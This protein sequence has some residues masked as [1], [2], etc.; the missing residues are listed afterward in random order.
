MNINLKDKVIAGIRMKNSTQSAFFVLA[1]IAFFSA[2]AA[3]Y[4]FTTPIGSVL[5]AG[6]TLGSPGSTKSLSSS[7]P[8]A[9]KEGSDGLYSIV[10]SPLD[11]PYTG[12]GVV[13]VS[14]SPFASTNGG[15]LTF[16]TFQA[17]SGGSTFDNIMQVSGSQEPDLLVNYGPLGE[18]E[19]LWLTGF[20]VYDQQTAPSVQSFALLD[21]G[22]AYQVTFNLPIHEPYSSNTVNQQTFQMLGQSWQI[23][24]YTLPSGTSSSSTTAV[25]GGKITV[26]SP[27]GSRWNLTN[28]QAL[29]QTLAPGWDVQLLWVNASGSGHYTDLQSIIIY[30][31]TPTMLLPGQS[32]SFVPPFSAWKLTFTGHTLGSNYDALTVSSTFAPA[33]AYKN[34]GTTSAGTGTGSIT[35]ITEPA[36]ELVLTS[37]IPNAFSYAGVSS[38]TATYVLTPYELNEYAHSSSSGNPVNVVLN[39]CMPQSPCSSAV[40]SADQLSVVLTGYTSSNSASP[41]STTLYF[42]SNSGVP[43]TSATSF[44]NIT[45]IKVSRALL[46]VTVTVTNSSG[47][48]LATLV[49]LS[50]AITYPQVGV[51]YSGLSTTTALTYNQQNGGPSATFGFTSTVSAATPG[52]PFT[53]DAY[54]ITEYNVPGSSSSTDS[55]IFNIDN[56]TAGWLASPLFQINFSQ[57]NVPNNLTYVSSQGHSVNARVGFVSE[58]GS[59]LAAISPTQIVLDLAKS[60][61]TLQFVVSQQSTVIT[62][63]TVT[64]TTITVQP[65]PS[66]TSTF[67]TTSTS[68]STTTTTISPVAGSYELILT[69][70]SLCASPISASSGYYAAASTVTISVSDCNGAEFTGWIGTGSGSYTG[71]VRTANVVMLGNIAEVA[72]YLTTTASTTSTSSTTSILPSNAYYLQMSATGRPSCAP[73]TAC[74]AYVLLLPN[75]CVSPSSGSYASGNTITIAANSTCNGAT[76]VDWSGTGA[77]S[78][79]GASASASVTMNGDITEDADYAIA[80]TGPTST[81]PT[82]SAVTTLPTTTISSYSTYTV[83]IQSGWNVFSVPLAYVTQLSGTCTSSNLMSPVWQLV[84][85]RYVQATFLYGGTGYWL[86]SDSDCSLTFSGPPLATAEAFTLTPGWN[87]VGS[88]GS[89][90]QFSDIS[91]GCNIVAGPYWYN[92]ASA[93]YQTESAMTPGQGY[94]ID[95]SSACNLGSSGS[96]STPPPLPSQS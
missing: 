62:S 28:G 66:S 8:Y 80:T 42:T 82:I 67:S 53:L 25:T 16:Q 96:S 38:S 90:T 12:F 59:K 35:N 81:T 30:N 93:S 21:A 34:L 36:Q 88:F 71:V 45:T 6:V 9:Y 51:L 41:V 91:G 29:N 27:Y 56:S 52:P 94:L 33:L 63:T 85:G 72:T 20:P 87:V 57:S 78:Y 24:G 32:L 39:V 4:T 19:Y 10:A 2:S 22:G 64:T 48:K 13:P 47:T 58:R 75:N 65:T 76:F 5:N 86:K 31:V 92:P 73:G 49:S 69:L 37:Q 60:V 68:T 46:G 40:N 43:V 61:D 1:L 70:G 54:E 44:Y 17:L 15:G 14:V 3:Q 23:V 84:N 55:F 74:P 83:N 50:P 77:G 26:V 11:S 79:S 95:V 18:S 89:T 7:S